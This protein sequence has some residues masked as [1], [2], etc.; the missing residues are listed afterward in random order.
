MGQPNYFCEKFYCKYCGSQVAIKVSGNNKVRCMGCDA[1][2][3]YDE[4]AIWRLMEA[5]DIPPP[6]PPSYKTGSS[7]M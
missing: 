7:Y 1:W 5:K 6:K 4:R 2:Y 3:I